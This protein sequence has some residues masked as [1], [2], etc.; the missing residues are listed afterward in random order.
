METILHSEPSGFISKV[1]GA[2]S[3]NTN[4][5]KPSLGGINQGHVG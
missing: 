1:T 2:V 4:V 5:P 3:L